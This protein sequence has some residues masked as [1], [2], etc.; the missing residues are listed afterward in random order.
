MGTWARKLPQDPDKRGGL[1]TKIGRRQY[2]GTYTRN[3]KNNGKL[4]L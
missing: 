1:N 3:E 4:Q 2:L